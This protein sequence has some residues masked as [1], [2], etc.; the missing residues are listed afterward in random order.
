MDDE[1]YDLFIK[2]H[3]STCERPELLGAGRHI[4]DI[5]EK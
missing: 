2:Y 5:L 1:T 3:L 4:L